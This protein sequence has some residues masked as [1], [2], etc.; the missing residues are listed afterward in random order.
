MRQ[1]IAPDH[2]VAALLGGTRIGFDAR[3]AVPDVGGIRR[4]AHLAVADDID[5]GCDLLRDGL[6]H[7]PR[8]LF[9]EDGRIDCPAPVPFEDELD[10]SL[11]PREAASMGGE[12]AVLARFHAAVPRQPCRGRS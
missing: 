1:E 2:D 12:D 9:L 5:T 11:R 8:D 10:E 6:I 4:L 3:D 7:R